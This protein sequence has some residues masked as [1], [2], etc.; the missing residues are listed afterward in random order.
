MSLRRCGASA[1]LPSLEHLYPLLCDPD[2][3]PV[4]GGARWARQ[5]LGRHS[6]RGQA[7]EDKLLRMNPR[8]VHGVAVMGNTTRRRDVT[9]FA[10]AAVVAV[11][12]GSDRPLSRR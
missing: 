5:S 10:D 1:A 6:P 3:D 11:A 2:S 12:R 9:A 4:R 8:A 7:E